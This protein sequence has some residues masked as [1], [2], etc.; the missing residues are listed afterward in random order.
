MSRRP[1]VG[2]AGF[3]EDQLAAVAEKASPGAVTGVEA[4][5]VGALKLSHACDQIG[6]G[7]LDEEMIMVAHQDPC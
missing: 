5:R 7:C 6:Q 2:S 3:N 4:S 1:F